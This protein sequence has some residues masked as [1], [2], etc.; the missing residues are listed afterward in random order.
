MRPTENKDFA[1]ARAENQNRVLCALRNKLTSPAIITEIPDLIRLFKGAI[2]TDLSPEQLG[3]LACIGTKIP[4]GNVL[5]ASFPAEHFRQTR[6][7]DPVFGKNVAVWEVDFKILRSYISLFNQGAW[8]NQET[9][10]TSSTEEQEST[11][12][13]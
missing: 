9:T 12:C 7:F 11:V 2:Q 6:Q 8:P 1:F 5:F 3:Q 10:A 13:P 4:S